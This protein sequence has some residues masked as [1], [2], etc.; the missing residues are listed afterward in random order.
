VLLLGLLGGAALWTGAALPNW[1]TPEGPEAVAAVAVEPEAEPEPVVE[2][3]LANPLEQADPTDPW[4]VDARAA[5]PT[6]G[7]CPAGWTQLDRVRVTAYA[8]AHEAAF[9]GP[10]LVDPCGLTGTYDGDFLFGRGVKL[11][12]SGRAADGS[13]V[14]WRDG[15]FETTA[16]PTTRSG[17]C[18]EAGR[19]VA[20]DP[21]L[22]P[23]GRTVWIEGV[24]KRVAEDT[25]G[26]IRGFKVDVW[27]GDDV[28][29]AEAFGVQRRRVCVAP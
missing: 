1:V 13:I 24:G 12:G 23:L 28:D 20:V 4:L 26:R 7:T 3:V 19:T 6:G 22:I 11:Q 9:D 16:C 25:G 17:T 14:A 15:C 2:W 29:G 10:D 18:A 8:L 27:M 5:E 21:R